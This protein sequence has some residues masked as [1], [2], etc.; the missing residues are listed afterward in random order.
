MAGPIHRNKPAAGA[1][2]KMTDQVEE[3]RE[4]IRL[5][6]ASY[7]RPYDDGMMVD[8]VLRAVVP[9]LYQVRAGTRADVEREHRALLEAPYA[10]TIDI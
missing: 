1:R 7:L 9:F 6:L 3:L 2:L 10:I 5:S 8:A 4:T